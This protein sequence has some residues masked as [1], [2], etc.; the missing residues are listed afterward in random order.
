[1]DK[2]NGKRIYTRHIETDFVVIL[3]T[4]Y[5]NL[6]RDYNIEND[7]TCLPP[8]AFVTAQIY[9][10]IS[11]YIAATPPPLLVHVHVHGRSLSG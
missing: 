4:G 9:I 2:G 7:N 11:V 6:R 8:V 3:D 5:G 1:M 10:Y